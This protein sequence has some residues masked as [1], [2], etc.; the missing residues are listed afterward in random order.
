MARRQA[1]LMYRRRTRLALFFQPSRLSRT[2]TSRKPLCTRVKAI[3]LM[4][5]TSSDE[6]RAVDLHAYEEHSIL[7]NA[8]C[9]I[10]ITPLINQKPLARTLQ[11]Y[12]G[13]TSHKMILFRE[14]SKTGFLSLTFSYSNW[15]SKRNLRTLPRYESNSC[16][17]SLPIFM[18]HCIR[19]NNVL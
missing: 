1:F 13:R 8:T 12:L 17:L 16:F 9:S 18:R 15:L 11:S 3:S 6:S 10:L 19:T 4:R 2:G 14:R 7:N 5:M